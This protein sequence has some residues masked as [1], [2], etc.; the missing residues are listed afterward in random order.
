VLAQTGVYLLRDR[1]ASGRIEWKDAQGR[2]LKERQEVEAG[3]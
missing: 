2:T 3:S 1:S